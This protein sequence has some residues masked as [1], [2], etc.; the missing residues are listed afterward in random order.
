MKI[1]EAQL[2]NWFTYH[3][4]T[5]E[6]QAKYD[7]ITEWMRRA[8][9]MIRDEDPAATHAI[10][11][12]VSLVAEMCPKGDERVWAIASLGEAKTSLDD[13]GP[14]IALMYLRAARMWAN[15]AIACEVKP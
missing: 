1:T 4:P 7:R 8:A 12:V 13:T 5:P 2:T 9:L 3:R 10:D 15:A 6:Q 11:D 14:R